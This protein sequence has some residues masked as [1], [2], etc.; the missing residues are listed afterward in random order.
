VTDP[1]ARRLRELNQP[2][3]MSLEECGDR[4]PRVGVRRG[5]G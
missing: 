5:I 4:L 1:P 3:R 2:Q